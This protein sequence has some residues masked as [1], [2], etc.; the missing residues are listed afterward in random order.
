MKRT[1]NI[2]LAAS[3]IL[4]CLPACAPLIVGGIAAGTALVATDRR[5]TGTQVD[6]QTIQL[7]VSEELRTS[8]HG[9]PVRI[10]VNSF[11]RKVLLTGEV[12]NEQVK[13]DAGAIAARSLN[14]RTVVNELTVGPPSTIGQRTND[15]ALGGRVR[16]AFIGT[17]DIAFNSVDIVTDR[18]NIY[19][20]G[21]VTEREAEVASSVASRVPGVQRVVK[22][23]DYASAEEVQRRRAIAAQP[24]PPTQSPAPIVTPPVTTTPGT[25]PR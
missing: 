13:A 5:T 25:A 4:A 3:A 10:S 16:A 22:V 2:L 24:A 18:G 11:E 19:L 17:R 23:F 7:R 21:L 12:P 14:V 20:M 1:I 8:L 15:V 6:D 9:G